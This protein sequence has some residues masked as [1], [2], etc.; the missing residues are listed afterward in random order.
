MARLAMAVVVL[1]LVGCDQDMTQQEKLL[2]DRATGLF[3][4][5]KVNQAPPA[6]SVA[7]DQAQLGRPPLTRALMERGRE[8]YG[9]ACAPCHGLAGD[10]DGIIARHGFPHPPSF[11]GDPLR[12]ADDDV[13]MAAI[14]QGYGVMYSYADRVAPADRWAIIAWIRVLQLSQAAPVNQIPPHLRRSLDQAGAAP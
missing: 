9:I 8:R 10:G 3:R 12:Q 11:H 6:G 4:D 1:A 5:G 2:P 7:Q 13:F 14:S